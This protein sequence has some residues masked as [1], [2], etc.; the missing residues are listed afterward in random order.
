MPRHP[1]VHLL[2][3]PTALLLLLLLLLLPACGTPGDGAPGL[4]G[5]FVDEEV[6]ITDMTSTPSGF[7]LSPEAALALVIGHW[8]GTLERYDGAAITLTLHTT[9][10]GAMLLQRRSWRSVEGPITEPASAPRIGVPGSTAPATGPGPGPGP[11]PT[12]DGLDTF[13]CEDTYALPVDLDL[14]ALPDLDVQ[15]ALRLTVSASGAASFGLRITT[16]EHTGSA[17]P[18]PDDLAGPGTITA[19]ELLV[20]GARGSGPWTGEVAFGFERHHG[21]DGGGDATVSYSQSEYA[22]WSA[23]AELTPAGRARR[24]AHRRVG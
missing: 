4:V 18:A 6:A 17:A 13:A 14:R 11:G 16:D 8:E 5:C 21:P 3:R 23:E 20:H 1:P 10:S 15:H 2:A 24:A 12:D 7:E 19:I 9:A 22:A